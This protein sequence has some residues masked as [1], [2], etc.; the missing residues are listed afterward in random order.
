MLSLVL[1]R[2]KAN[3]DGTNVAHNPHVLVWSRLLH[4]IV[5]VDDLLAIQ[6]R[7]KV[8]S[9]LNSVRTALDLCLYNLLIIRFIFNAL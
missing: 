5:N 3:R 7:A 4:L 6:H 9:M 8:L 1:D 2:V